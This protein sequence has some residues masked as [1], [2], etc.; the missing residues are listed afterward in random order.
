LGFGP[1]RS[2]HLAQQQERIWQRYQLDPDRS[3]R[4]S[5]SLR[6]FTAQTLANPAFAPRS[7]DQSE[8]MAMLE[9]E[10][11]RAASGEASGSDAMA[12]AQAAWEQLDANRPP[13]QTLDWRRKSAGLE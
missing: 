3:R 4:L 11:R 12:A 10:V 13:Q 1:F 2:E 5:E 7:P 9:K 8:L 6:Q